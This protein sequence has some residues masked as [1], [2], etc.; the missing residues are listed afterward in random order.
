MDGPAAILP[1]QTIDQARDQI[2]EQCFSA[3]GT[4][5]VGLECEWHVFDV[6]DEQRIV[7]LDFVEHLVAGVGPLPGGSRVTF[8]PGGQLELSSPPA[9]GVDALVLRAFDYLQRV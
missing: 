4:G 2:H 6:A 1:I 8:E 5:R 9:H 7:P 3:S